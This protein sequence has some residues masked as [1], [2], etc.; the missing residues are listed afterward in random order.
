MSEM[1]YTVPGMHCGNCERAVREEV[2]TVAGVELVEVDLESKRVSV[3]GE[4]L[5]DAAI[6]AAISEAGYEA[7]H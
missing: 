3:R 1:A 7:E 6:R 5:D 4:S 2:S